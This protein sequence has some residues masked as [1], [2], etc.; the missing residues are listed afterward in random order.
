MIK[1][2]LPH[3]LAKHVVGGLS[4][5]WDAFIIEKIIGDKIISF[6]FARAR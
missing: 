4:F 6:D 2:S 1:L 5:L 3:K